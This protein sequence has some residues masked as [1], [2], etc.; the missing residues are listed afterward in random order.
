MDSSESKSDTEERE[1][2]EIQFKKN[3][4]TKDRKIEKKVKNYTMS[5]AQQMDADIQKY[6]DKKAK[7]EGGYNPFSFQGGNKTKTQQP[8]RKLKR[9]KT[10]K[11]TKDYNAYSKH[12]VKKDNKLIK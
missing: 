11:V 12:V 9:K 5:K 6:F 1:Q 8:K 4:K 10:K 7:T 2:R 3:Q